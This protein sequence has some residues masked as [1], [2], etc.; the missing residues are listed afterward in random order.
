VA[1]VAVFFFDAFRANWSSIREFDLRLRAL[2]L[3]GALGLTL[4]GYCSSR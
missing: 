1:G 3:A 2:P 4:A